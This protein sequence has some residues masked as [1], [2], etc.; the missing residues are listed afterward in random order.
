MELFRVNF[1]KINIKIGA[2]DS[3]I[4][5]R[6]TRIDYAFAADDSGSVMYYNNVAKKKQVITLK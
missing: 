1:C 3:A 2:C 5:A 6:D 4:S